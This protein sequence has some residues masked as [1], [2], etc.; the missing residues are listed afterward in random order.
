M[1]IN[2]NDTFELR[3]YYCFKEVKRFEN[4]LFANITM[5]TS[6]SCS[7]NNL[8]NGSFVNFIPENIETNVIDNKRCI[9]GYIY[10][11]QV[12]SQAI[13]LRIADHDCNIQ[14]NCKWHLL[15]MG[16]FTASFESQF[17]PL[18]KTT[19]GKASTLSKYVV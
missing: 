8:S 12:S 6:L 1:Q 15:S 3:K 11:M 14:N 13:T 19:T 5:S 16:A 18:Q 7:L 4:G 17:E 2:I 10:K 9:F